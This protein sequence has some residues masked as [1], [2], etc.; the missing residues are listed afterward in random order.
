MT[1]AMHVINYLDMNDTEKAT[2][3]LDERSYSVYIRKPFQVWSEVTEKFVGA[4]NFITGAGGFLQVIINGYGGVRLLDDSL[5][6][7]HG[8]VPPKTTQLSFNGLNY[9]GSVFKL[10]VNSG[11]SSKIQFLSF[12]NDI[13][14]KITKNDAEVCATGTA[15]E[16][17]IELNHSDELVMAAKTSPFGD[18]CAMGD[19]K[20]KT[21]D[22]SAGNLVDMSLMLALI[23]AISR[24]LF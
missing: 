7:R 4:G 22:V 2:D 23:C 20:I 16:C 8:R 21:V 1:W 9:L 11:D 12:N 15:T 10:E 6:I 18:T 14:L 19:G 5:I 17:V 13:K 24:Y 3:I